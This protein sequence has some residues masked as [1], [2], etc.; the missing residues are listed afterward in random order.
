MAPSQVTIEY[1]GQPF[2]WDKQI[3]VINPMHFISDQGGYLSPLMAWYPLPGERRLVIAVLGGRYW[4][5]PSDEPLLPALVPMQLTWNGPT[6]LNVVSNLD[7]VEVLATS[8]GAKAVFRG[9]SD[10]VS[11]LIGSLDTLQSGDFTLF[12]ACEWPWSLSPNRIV[13]ASRRKTGRG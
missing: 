10:G 13:A 2:L 12:G 9:H 3:G 8:G 6:D 7:S 4:T 5:R 11:L 1:S